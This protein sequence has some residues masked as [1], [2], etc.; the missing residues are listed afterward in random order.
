MKRFLLGVAL[1]VSSCWLAAA[2]TYP[3]QR[4]TLIV[5]FGAGSGTD[6]VS[7]IVFQRVSELLKTPIIIEN[8]VGANGAVGAAAAARSAPDGYT[9]MAGGSSTHAANPSMLKSIQYDPKADFAPISQL[10]LYPY[11]L[12]VNPEVPAKTVRDLVALAR[13]KPGSLS[14][15]YANAIGQLSGEML[16]KRAGVDLV[17]VPY[18]NSPQGITDLIAGRV[19]MMFLDMPPALPQVQAGLARALA[20]T[21]KNRTVLFPSIPS[22]TEEG[23]QLFD[24]SAWTGVFAPKGTPPEIVSK[25]ADT[26]HQVLDE[27]DMRKRLAAIGFEAQWLGPKPFSQHVSDDLDLWANLTR[28]AGIERQ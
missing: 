23:V 14:F 6:A 5:P 19:S 26:L 15:A 3:S 13:D 27:P 18:R 20:T 22:M 11:F 28:E 10:G 8:R 24:L 16:K 2:E 17:A 9:L 21:T 1:L 25:L 7:R 4:I 12:I